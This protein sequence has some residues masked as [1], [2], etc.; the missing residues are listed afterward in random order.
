MA[1]RPTSAE[2]LELVRSLVTPAEGCSLAFEKLESHRTY[3]AMA[4]CTHPTPCVP[5]RL[6]LSLALTNTHIHMPMT[7]PRHVAE[8]CQRV[9]P[10]CEIFQRPYRANDSI[11]VAFRT[12]EVRR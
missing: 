1:H 7:R 11:I 5:S 12:L 9:H 10:T 8:L 2:F 6:V 3:V 4:M